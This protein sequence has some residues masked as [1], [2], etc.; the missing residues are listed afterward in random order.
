MIEDTQVCHALDEKS[1]PWIFLRSTACI[2]LSLIFFLLLF[3]LFQITSI[4]LLHRKEQ[5]NKN[6]FNDENT[7][8]DS[9]LLMADNLEDKAPLLNHM[10]DDSIRDDPVLSNDVPLR[11]RSSTLHC[12]VPDE[13]FDYNARN[14]LLVVFLL[15]IIFMIIEIIGM[16]IY[17]KFNQR[18]FLLFI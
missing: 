3:F 7:F 5:D 8:N 15:C 11:P 12:H 9:L 1:S 6:N 18:K 16:C 2:D 17:N 13:N 14:R 10:D 4:I